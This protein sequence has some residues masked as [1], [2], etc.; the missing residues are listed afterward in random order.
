MVQTV[1][2]VLALALHSRCTVVAVPKSQNNL[3]I[4][5]G[6]WSL[7]IDGSAMPNPG[8]M[9]IGAVLLDPQG[10]SYALSQCLPGQGCNNEAELQALAHALHHVQ[11]HGGGCVVVHTD[12]AVLVEQLVPPT[13]GR[14]AKPIARLA[15]QFEQ[16]RAQMAMLARVEL[17]WVPRHRNTAADAL[18]RAALQPVL[19]MPAACY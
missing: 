5:E 15:L 17:R 3:P 2:L 10:Q 6:H 13:G 16:V 7:H 4:P 1:Q 12:S 8:Q 18:A 19:S 14:P 9:A 11:L